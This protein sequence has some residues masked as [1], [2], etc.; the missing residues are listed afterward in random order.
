MKQVS[1]VSKSND[2]MTM[3]LSARS[4]HR[5]LHAHISELRRQRSLQWPQAVAISGEG[6]QERPPA[7]REYLVAQLLIQFVNPLCGHAG[8]QAG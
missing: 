6:K 3:S 5:V 8:G 2:V 7:L 4:F 1:F